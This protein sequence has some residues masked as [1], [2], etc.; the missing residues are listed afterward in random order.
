M[1]SGYDGFIHGLYFGTDALLGGDPVKCIKKHDKYG[2]LIDTVKENETK[3]S[4][5]QDS[6]DILL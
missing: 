5:K 3:K 1:N 2:Q 6:G 4:N